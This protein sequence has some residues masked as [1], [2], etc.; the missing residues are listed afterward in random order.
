MGVFTAAAAR[1]VSG[2]TGGP[3]CAAANCKVFDASATVSIV[4]ENV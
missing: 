3:D 4:E 1:N 2:L